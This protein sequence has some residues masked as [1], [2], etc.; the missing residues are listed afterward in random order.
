VSRRER[1]GTPAAP[2]PYRVA[3]WGKF[4]SLEPVF[5]DERACLTAK[6]GLPPRLDDLVL[7]VPVHGDRRRIVE[8][9][10]P[11]DDLASVLR[12]LLW[13][14]GVR[15]GFGDDVTGEAAAVA[16]RA[17]R[18]DDG[19]RDLAGLPTFTI[20]PDTARDFDD[21]ISVAAEPG[22]GYRAHVHIAD[23]SYFVDEDG[24]IDREARRRTSSVYLP[25]FAEPMLPAALSSDLCSLVPRQPRK[26]MTV[27]FTFD[28]QGR[29]TAVQFY[30]SLIR[31][32]HR[33]TYGFA[34]AVLAAHGADGAAL[35]L[36]PAGAGREAAAEAAVALPAPSELEALRA[37]PPAPA[38]APGE[39]PGPALKSPTEPA[40]AG[41]ADESP[42]LAD[43]QAGAADGPP[44]LA[45]E[46]PGLAIEPPPA[47]PDATTEADEALVVQLRLAY[48][49][50]VVLR[51]RRFAR[52]ALVLGSFE[53]E[54]RFTAT[55]ELLG[56][57]ARPETASHALV[58]EFMLAANE[59]VA[60]FLLKRRAPAIYRVHEP[61]DRGSAV[62]LWEAL[63]ELGLR[64]PPLPGGEHLEAG[65]L[66]AA[67]GRLTRA[68]A[69][70]VAREGRGRIAFGQRVLRSLKQA[71]YAPSN[72]GHFGLASPAYL[73]F[74]SPIRRYPDLVVH[75]ALAR[76]IAAAGGAPPSTDELLGVAEAC[77]TVER[78]FSRL[79]LDAD[80]VAL[81]FL[82]GARLTRE[83]WDTEFE[84]EIVG[85][86][87]SGVFVHFG[88][89]YEGFLP[90]RRLG[91]ER[92]HLSDHETAQVGDDSG[93]RLRLG[94]PIRVRV[95]RVDRLRGRVDLVPA[96]EP[97]QG[98]HTRP[99]RAPAR[100]TTGGRPPR[101][102]R[103]GRGGPLTPPSRSG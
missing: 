100:R 24:A 68:V 83:G 102:R 63:E 77:S 74:T 17:A 101:R 62:E 73:H 52:G 8:V 85:L 11:A 103:P 3:R 94:D 18:E 72:L 47:V 14:K 59:A 80:A 81:S 86:V 1:T 46:P 42:G 88:G 19:R 57:A 41:A 34:D 39:S 98:P 90:L 10:G 30:R 5:G 71:R 69:E 7:A 60:E 56:A 32:D 27:E 31:S 96:V 35:G 66:A 82:L 53:P 12:A 84:G 36:L 29:R 58:E 99:G 15:Q 95:E 64:V 16:A 55:G 91:T 40:S 23:V 75:R 38:G 2:L 54:Y 44:R 93:R 9:L 70:T 25:L 89:C 43:E 45:T 49:L 79:E 50:A 92:Y 20:D 28:E 22:G 4:W 76:E 87:A 26:C 6:G 65:Q 13:A 78:E 61:P 21:A 51:R 67:Y 37:A 48:E 33:L 97:G